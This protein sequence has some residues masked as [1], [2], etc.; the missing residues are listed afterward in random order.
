MITFSNFKVFPCYMLPRMFPMKNHCK[1]SA[2]LLVGPCKVIQKEI[3]SIAKLLQKLLLTIHS[4]IVLDWIAKL[5][6][7]NGRVEII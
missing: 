3:G 5:Y 4:L 1:P 6:D 2:T 7:W